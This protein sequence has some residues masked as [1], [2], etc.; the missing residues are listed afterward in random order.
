M[1]PA[2]EDERLLTAVAAGRVPSLL[3]ANLLAYAEAVANDT[4]RW[5]R[6]AATVAMLNGYLRPKFPR[7]DDR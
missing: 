5:S 7:G 4:G 3:G 6:T 2:S 1:P